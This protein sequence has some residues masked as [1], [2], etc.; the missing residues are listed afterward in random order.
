MARL[1][2]DNAGERFWETGV[3]RAV[4]YVGNSAEAWSGVTA[5]NESPSGS[6]PTKIYAD[7]VVYGIVM[8]PE[9]NA[10]TIEAFQYPELFS[11][12]VGKVELGKGAY[13]GQQDHVP[14]AL[15]WRSMIG[16]DLTNNAGYKLHIVPVLYA[17]SSE[18][19]SSTI[20][21]SPEQKS[22]SW[23]ATAIPF[24]VDEEHNA[25]SVVLDSRVFNK[26]G[27]WN[28][29]MAIEDLLYGTNNT[30]AKMP[31]ISKI[32]EI[33]DSADAITDSN[34]NSILDSTNDIIRSN[35]FMTV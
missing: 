8:S 13:I 21:D 35:A 10:V 33:A 20:N 2:W 17:S 3:D 32:F 14:F 9:E 11:K 31:T 27:R 12:C 1:K 5:I 25:S 23:S 26:T 28:A 29:L 30:D 6:E 7:N 4:L 19:S 22:F 18:D 15:C 34:G 16:N 24:K